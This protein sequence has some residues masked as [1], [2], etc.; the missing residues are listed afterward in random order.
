LRSIHSRDVS[1][2]EGDTMTES[3]GYVLGQS[4][5][6]ARRLEIQDAH[7][8]DASER[9]LDDLALRPNDRVVEFGCGPGGFSRRILHRL[10]EGGVLVGVDSSPGLLTQ[11]SAALAG[12]GPARFEPVSADLA[13]LGPWLDGA[14]VVVARTVLHH[15]PMAEFVLGRLRAALRPGTRVGFIEPDFRTLLAR[16]TYL[17]V[18]GRRELAPLRL[19]AVAI[20][21]LYLANR[22]SPDVGATLAPA[23]EAA[24]YRRVRG[25]WSEGRSDAIGI[26]NMLMFYD[27]VRDRLQAL[28]ILTAAEVDEQQRLLRALPADGLPAVWGI[29]RVACEA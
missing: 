11:A 20:N 21:Q 4:A 19:W 23:L 18:T 22:L 1:K 2:V 27:E 14:D 29:H 3:Q 24:G 9:L 13:G 16:L 15:V 12:A 6:A 25:Q 17:E 26:E 28:G 10:G 7:F 8:A 5:R